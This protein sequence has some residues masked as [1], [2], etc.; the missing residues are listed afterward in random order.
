MT[1]TKTASVIFETTVSVPVLSSRQ[2]NN[3]MDKI[4]AIDAQIKALQEA[5]DALKTE[6]INAMD[7]DLMETDRYKIHNTR[8]TSNKFDSKSFKADHARLYNQCTKETS[9]TRFSYST[10]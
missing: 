3:R 7:S 10:K 1:N 4:A 6:I 8:V 5:R 9:S 2:V